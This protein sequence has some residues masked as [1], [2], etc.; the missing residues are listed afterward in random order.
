MS[1]DTK[2]S[3]DAAK[4]ALESEMKERADRCAGE[5]QKLL[6]THN[7]DVRIS[8]LVTQQG[9]MPQLQFVPKPL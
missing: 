2:I 3:T 6:E 4:A 9:N 1:N 7:C 8:M 5:F